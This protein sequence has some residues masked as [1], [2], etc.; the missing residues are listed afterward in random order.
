MHERVLTQ[1]QKLYEIFHGT[2]LLAFM[3]DC[4]SCTDKFGTVC[5]VIDSGGLANG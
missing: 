1:E 2:D 5:I 3:A 4:R